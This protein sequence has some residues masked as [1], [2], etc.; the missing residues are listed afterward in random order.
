MFKAT[1]SPSIMAHVLNGLLLLITLWFSLYHYHTLVN[2]DVYQ[3]LVLL[4]LL[5][6]IIGLHG[7]SHLGLE[8]VYRLNPLTNIHTRKNTGN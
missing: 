2:L 3:K 4:S 8:Q 5:T 1:L 6:L 7:L